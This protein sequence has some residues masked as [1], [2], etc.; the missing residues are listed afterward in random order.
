MWSF[1]FYIFKTVFKSL[2]GLAVSRLELGG[3]LGQPKDRI[4]VSSGSVVRGYSKK[5]KQ[6]LDFNTN[7]T[8]SIKNMWVIIK[9]FVEMYTAVLPSVTE[10]WIEVLIEDSDLEILDVMSALTN[11][12]N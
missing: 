4:F 12:F 10:N 3:P 5:G 7:I 6:F 2:P 1:L 9:Y 11:C 8:E